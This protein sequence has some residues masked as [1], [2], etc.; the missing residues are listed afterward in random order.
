[1]DA[2]PPYP[3]NSPI[4]CGIDINVT[5]AR[6]MPARRLT[7]RYACPDTPFSDRH[8]STGH[9]MEG[10]TNWQRKEVSRRVL[11]LTSAALTSVRPEY[12][13]EKRRAEFC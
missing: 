13:N 9:A 3:P 5:N 7:I 11:Y 12:P 10:G 6:N 8:I 4:T 1:M 2:P